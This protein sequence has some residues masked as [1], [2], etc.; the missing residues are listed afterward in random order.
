MMR[1][2]PSA[3]RSPGRSTGKFASDCSLEALFISDVCGVWVD[4]GLGW[5]VALFAGDV[6]G[7]GNALL[8]SDLGDLDKAKRTREVVDLSLLSD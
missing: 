2:S 3:M 7:W 8:G 1:E 6:G 5:S 4:A